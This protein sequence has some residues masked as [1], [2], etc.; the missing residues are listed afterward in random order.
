MNYLFFIISFLVTASYGV[1]IHIIGGN[2]VSNSN[3]NYRAIASLQRGRRRRQHYCGGVLVSPSWVMTAAHCVKNGLP[4]RIRVAS[5]RT[6]RGGFTRKATRVVIHPKNV[7]LLND[8]ALLHLLKPI[9]ASV[10]PMSLDDGTY[11]V[12]GTTI[13]S[14]GWGYTKEWSGV[15]MNDLR[16]VDL[17]VLSYD[18]CKSAYGSRVKSDQMLCTLGTWN[19]ATGQRGD[20]CSG[21]SGSPN[22]YHDDNT[23]VVVGITSWGKG[24]GTKNNPGVTTRVSTYV[25][26]IKSVIGS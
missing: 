18:E 14:V 15:M 3:N 20:A 13:T 9:P 12:D 11:G 1:D 21:D 16:E 4:T 22:I 26:W 10:P 24:C 17:Q 5:Y 8:I 19:D 23:R 7:G 6:A 25:P 2:K